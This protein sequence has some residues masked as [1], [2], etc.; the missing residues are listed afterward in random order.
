[1][2][3]R[4]NTPNTPAA[5]S[6]QAS[7]PARVPAGKGPARLDVSMEELETILEHAKAGA[8]GQQELSVLQAAIQTLCFLTRE[9][10]KK[11]VSIQ[12]LRQL[13]FGAATETTAKLMQK[14]LE[15][16]GRGEE[17][18]TADQSVG[19]A[20]VAAAAETPADA[21]TRPK[22]H[23]RNGADAYRGVKRIQV[24]LGSLKAGDACPDCTKGTVYASCPPGL[25]VRLTGQAPIGGSVYELQKL[26]CNLCGKLF[27]AAA[28]EGVGDK[29]YDEQSAAM[30]ALLKYGTG[31]P[32]HRLAGL[33]QDLGI[34]LPEATQWQ[35][36]RQAAWSVM[37]AFTELIRQAAQGQVLYNDD[38]TMKVLGLATAAHQPAS[39]AAGIPTPASPQ[40]PGGPEEPTRR[41]VFTSGI[42]AQVDGHR[43]ALFFTGHRHAGENLLQV[44][45]QRCAELGPPIQMCDALS[46]NMPEA[47][48]TILANCLAHGRRKFVDVLEAF[49]QQCLHVLQVL[50]DVYRNDAI[51]RQQ[52][53]TAQQRLEFHQTHSTPKMDELRSWMQQQFQQRRVEPNS[54]L[55]EA[56]TYTHKHW[57]ALTLFLHV[58]GAPLDNNVCERALKMAI[59]HRKN[60]YFYK[61]ANGARVGDLYMSLIHTCQ[62]NGGN[63]FHYLTQLQKHAPDVAAVP[64]DWMP[65][66]YP[67]AANFGQ[68][69]PAG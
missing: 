24:G 20:G 46:R 15:S 6:S 31:L 33:Q 1:M 37:P 48:K 64:T 66:N 47:L 17:N 14:V 45:K 29:K 67:A 34:P 16:A 7:E 30:I 23:G 27:T 32:F 62:L 54:A 18:K 50:K 10:E 68:G 69:G 38:T 4:G 11:S 43:I 42:I 13:L 21:E 56:I 2:E 63:P 52:N 44:L 28:P 49:P 59:L 57:E 22:G 25:I 41:G 58:P 40:V 55:G 19:E 65:W 61:T 12:R 35:I 60:A 39:S 5:G 51:A 26:R 53:M 36:V 8:L 3:E 9:L